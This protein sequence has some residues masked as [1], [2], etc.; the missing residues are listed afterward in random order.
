VTRIDTV[1]HEIRKFFVGYISVFVLLLL[2]C[3]IYLDW[4]ILPYRIFEIVCV[5]NI[6]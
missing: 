3:Y 2:G 1:I 6:K 4:T 5:E